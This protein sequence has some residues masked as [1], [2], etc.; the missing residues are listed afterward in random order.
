M[1]K[2]HNPVIYAPSLGKNLSSYP[3][4]QSIIAIM[5]IL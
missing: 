3:R 5:Y 1:T 2:L 4:P